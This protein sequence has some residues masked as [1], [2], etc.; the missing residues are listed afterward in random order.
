MEHVLTWTDLV[1]IGIAI[2]AA[3]LFG[4]FVLSL[5]WMVCVGIIVGGWS[6]IMLIWTNVTGGQHGD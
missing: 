6:L 1:W 4:Q 5:I 2:G 3:L